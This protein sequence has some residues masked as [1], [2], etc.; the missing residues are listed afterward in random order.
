MP[1]ATSRAIDPVGMTSIGLAGVVA[2]AH[3]RALAVLLLDLPITSLA[4]VLRCG[5]ATHHPS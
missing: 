3:H 4:L 2:Q 5:H 1:S